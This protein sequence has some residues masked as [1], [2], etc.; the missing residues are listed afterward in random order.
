MVNIKYLEFSVTVKTRQKNKTS[1]IAV[2]SFEVIENRCINIVNDPLRYGIFL[3]KWKFTRI[4]QIENS[5]LAEEFRPINTVL[6][7][8]KILELAVKSGYNSYTEL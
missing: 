1:L 8:E 6:S 7:Y 5:N 2:D 3:E 4:V